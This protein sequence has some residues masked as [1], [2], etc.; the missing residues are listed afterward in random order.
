MP[1]SFMLF[2]LLSL[3]FASG[4]FGDKDPSDDSA[5]DT[6]PEVIDADGDGV[7]AEDDCD[8]NDASVYPGAA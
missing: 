7:R 1:R 8:D 2:S 3:A 5:V 6:E 4:C